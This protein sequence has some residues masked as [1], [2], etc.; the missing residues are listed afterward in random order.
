MISIIITAYKEPKTIGKAIE[1]ILANN[2]PDKYELLV[3]A[4]DEQTLRVAE[5]YK[6]QNKNIKLIQDSGQGK[7]AA[8]NLAF[9]KAKGEILILTDG[10]VYINKQAIPLILEK[11][12]DPKIGAVSGRPISINS[13]KT[14]LG[15]WGYLLFDIAHKR[16]LKALELNKRIF[17]S[18][19]LYAF[20]KNLIKEIPAQTLSEDGL[21]SHL[22]Y[23]KGYKITYSPE[24][25][26]YIK[27]PTKFKDWILQKKRSV[28]GYNQIKSWIGT[29]IRSFKKE[30]FAI[31]DVF[32]YIKNLKEFFYT[33]ALI[34]ARLYLWIVIFIDINIKKKEFKK[35]WLRV[36][37]TK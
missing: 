9:K 23:S 12:K 35:I 36:E 8:L 10:D 18:G 16:R 25:E 22:I 26:V 7:P 3:F 19:Y 33:F 13:K 37:S 17:C 27:Y 31:L 28:G 32:K 4:P 21:I 30:S 34:L 14:M 2:I 29:E 11:F 20:R 6:K 15:F 1:A 5:K 24:A